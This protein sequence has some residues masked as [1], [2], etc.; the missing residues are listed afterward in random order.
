MIDIFT[1]II[2]INGED[3][4]YK[5]DKACEAIKDGQVVAIPTETVY[6]LGANA[7]SSD[8]AKKIYEVKGRPSDN[9]LIVHIAEK[10]DAKEIA[11]YLPESFYKLADAFWP[12]PLTMIVKKSEKIPYTVTAGLDTVGIRMPDNECTRYL[13]RKSGCPVAAPS[14]NIS[15]TVSATDAKY[16]YDDFNGKIPYIIDSGSSKIGLESTVINLTLTP[17]VILRPG[18]ITLEE[19]REYIPDAVYHDSLIEEEEEV[20][21]PASPGMKYKHYSPSCPVVLIKGGLSTAERYILDKI[22]DN[23]A[24][25][26]FSEQKKIA[27][28]TPDFC[29][30][31]YGSLSKCAELV[32]SHL[33]A[34]DK[35][36]YKKI[37]ITGVPE[38]GLGLSIMNRLKKSAGENAVQLRDIVFVC[39]GNTC[40]SPMAE[41]ILKSY[42][43]PNMYVKS[44]GLDVCCSSGM[45]FNSQKALKD[46]DIPFSDFHSS[47]LTYG[48]VADAD[49]VYTMTDSQRRIII[50]AF[51][52]FKDKIL[53][54]KENSDIADPYMHSMDF[55]QVTFDEIRAAIEKRFKDEL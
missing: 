4:F 28:I 15:G 47:Q 1:E 21:N 29:L 12:G 37:Y 48:D 50:S 13:I 32:F 5:L 42:N 26:Y 55:Y 14:A 10:Q 36:G 49:K 27:H 54:L 17:P 2:R 20:I 52:E 44:R 41:F 6:G 53:T 31:S 23:E 33:R 38:K 9:P 25:L 30:G 16:V 39:T 35:A 8:S 22:E 51:P 34:A 18:R 40:R 46:N 43:I 45:A 7:F 3:E 19:I 11:S 24:V